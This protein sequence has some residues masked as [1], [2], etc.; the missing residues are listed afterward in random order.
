[1]TYKKHLPK[2][3]FFALLLF[4]AIACGD[5]KEEKLR[6][7]ERQLDSLS[8]E[9]TEH[10]KRSDSLQLLLE[11]SGLAA[12]YPVVYGKGFDTIPNPQEYI[13]EAIKQH[14]NLIPIDA[15]LGGTMEFRQ[16]QVLTE[17]WVLATYDDGHVQGRSIFS[18]QLQPDGSIEFGHIA[19]KLPE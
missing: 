14:E 19:S 16:V 13:A 9:L 15:V 5:D 3:A 8:N 4:T 17:D 18:Y 12:S 6:E 10:R 2:V 11:K 1:M 7:T